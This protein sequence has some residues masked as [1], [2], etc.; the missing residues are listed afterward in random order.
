[1]RF[2]S[3]GL[4]AAVGG[5]RLVDLTIRR[6]SCVLR[7]KTSIRSARASTDSSG[8]VVARFEYEPFGLVVTSIGP[9]ASEAH[10]FTGKP[11]DG[12]I[13][14]YYFGA[15]Y[16]DPETGRFISRDPARDGLNWYEY[17]RSN[18]LV[19][20]DPNGLWDQKDHHDLTLDIATKAGF[21]EEWAGWIAQGARDC[22][23]PIYCAIVQP[24]RHFNTN[25]PHQ[26]DSRI[27]HFNEELRIA[28]V[29][30]ARGDIRDAMWHFGLGLHSLQDIDAHG[31]VRPIDHLLWFG[32]DDPRVEVPGPR[33]LLAEGKVSKRFE[34]AFH[35]M[36]VRV[37]KSFKA[38]VDST[39]QRP[40]AGGGS[41]T[42]KILAW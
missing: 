23:S 40:G 34:R 42:E 9:L 36:T 11:E 29:K 37:L 21:S 14:L 18:P 26:I 12:A 8:E 15:R 2:G 10:R 19:R 25:E 33:P 28:M 27:E 31:D 35:K 13:G 7:M 17:C 16:Y 38:M 24:S 4:C 1:M 6:C 3:P 39:M 22:D 30:L 41:G 20:Y 32:Y 5:G